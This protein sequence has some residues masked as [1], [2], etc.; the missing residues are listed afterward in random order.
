MLKII[1]ITEF[2]NHFETSGQDGGVGR[3]T[4]PPRT[5]KTRTT[6]NL[7]TKNNQ[8]WQKIK[9]YGSPTT[10]EMKKKH[11]SRRVGG[12]ETGSRAERTPGMAAAGRHDEA[13]DCRP[14]GLT[15]E[16][17]QTGRNNWGVRQ[18][19]QPRVPAQGNKASNFWLK[20]PVGVEAAVEKTPSLT[21]EFIGETHRVL[22]CSQAHPPGNQH[23]K[24]PIW[25][26]VAGEV[27]ENQQRAEQASLLP[28]DPSPTYSATQQQL[29]LS[30]PGEHL[31][32]APY[33][34]ISNP[35]QKKKKKRGPNEKTDQSSRKKHNEAMKR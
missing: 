24:G 29:G 14:G 35:D 22:E 17:R 28:L 18:T 12:V 11:S 4:V 21:G 13:V 19:K 23:Q 32:S 5:T 31:G 10:K 3:H 2:E 27:T 33:S 25:W 8:N 30:C 9:L 6:T 20:T 15:F 1:E 7:K 16:C 34:I 26:W